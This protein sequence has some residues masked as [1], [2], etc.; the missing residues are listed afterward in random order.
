M[1]SLA[2][3]C[4]VVGV[5]APDQDVARLAYYA[6][7][8]LQHRGQ[9][10]SGIVTTDGNCFSSC[11]G[12]GL[13]AQVYTDECIKELKGFAA[14]GHNRYATSGA[15]HYNHNQPVL[16]T[17]DV[18]ALAHNGNIPSTTALHEFLLDKGLYK[19]GSNDSEMMCDTIRYW[20]YQG[21]TM[22]ESIRHAWPLFTGA[23]S[24]VLLSQD[25][26]F[27][28]RDMYGIRPLSLGR[29][30]DGGYIVASETCAFDMVGASFERDIEPGE[31]VEIH[32][33]KLTSHQIAPANEKLEIFEYIY[34]ARPD[35]VLQGQSINEVRR[36]LGE[37]LADEAPAKADIVI[38]V[39]D[40]SIPAALGYATHLDLPFDHG[41]IK[42]RYIHRTFITPTQAMRER[43]VRMKLNPLTEVI[44]GKSVVLVD[45]SI[46]RGTTTQQIV[47]L[48]RNAGASQVHVRVSSP[49]VLYPDF[50]GID[51]PDQKQLIAA[52]MKSINRIS[53]HIGAD[54][55]AYLSFDSTIDAIGVEKDR[56]CH[57]CFSGEYPIDLIERQ[58]EVSLQKFIGNLA[59]TTT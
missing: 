7:S 50:Y 43:A 55:L 3:K 46:V 17:D 1:S 52:R 37:K 36:R 20:R 31:V 57:A 8:A 51:T 15:K 28:F 58:S 4:A 10:S 47:R 2:E 26:L 45:D 32:N 41:L 18:M 35:S 23:F 33:G 48:L 6:L 44:R 12:D 54:S 16:R 56:L 25:S 42:N 30:E 49:P 9:E 34:F 22:L 24:C 13:V 5:Y 40:S 11:I 29:F 19:H 59:T 27:A 53:E 21:E 38:P 39:P 14:V